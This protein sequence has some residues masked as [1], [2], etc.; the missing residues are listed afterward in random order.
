MLSLFSEKILSNLKK[1]SF[2]RLYAG[3]LAL[4][5]LLFMTYFLLYRKLEIASVLLLMIS[6]VIVLCCGGKAEKIIY[7][8]FL[9]ILVCVE[10]HFILHYNE[11][12]VKIGA[13][14]FITLHITS[15]EECRT[16]LSL[17]KWAEFILPLFFL[18]GIVA[19]CISQGRHRW[20]R[21]WGFAAFGCFFGAVFLN[22]FPPLREYSE[23]WSVQKEFLLARGRFRF[24][25]S[26]V[27]REARSLRI[28]IIGESH[29]QDYSDS[30]MITR[31]YAPLLWNAKKDGTA[32]F[33]SD[34]VSLYPQTWF[35]VF[36][37]LTRR[38]GND[39]ALYFSEK[40]LPSLFKEAGYKT[41]WV[42]YQPRGFAHSGYDSLVDECDAFYN[43]RDES[44]SKTDMGMLPIIKRLAGGKEDKIL[45]VIK[46]VGAHF[47]FHTRYPD[48]FK[49]YTPAYDEKTFSG[50][51]IEQKE[52]LINSYKNAMAYSGTVLDAIADV[53]KTSDASAMMAFISDHGMGLYDDNEQPFFGAIKGNYHIPFFIYGNDVY[54]KNLPDAKR[55]NLM[56]HRDIPVTTRYLFDTFV[57][58]SG[59]TYPQHRPAFDLTAPEMVPPKTRNV[60]V[61]NEQRDYETLHG[62]VGGDGR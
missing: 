39:R 12:F 45:I 24:D 53:V 16:Y 62:S 52:L 54:W 61:W 49:I 44:G 6:G 30:C 58:A 2:Y 29:R 59:V 46:M 20:S 10:R 22:V 1:A 14:A 35:A 11:P 32:I 34:M 25:A 23:Q 50:N 7:I 42:T 15:P 31:Q 17:L 48:E 19:V 18:G 27:S 28:L 3:E 40:G 37:E 26:D 47:N 13:Q 43:H 57:S 5:A 4:T 56:R 60:W 36:T 8:L 38:D 33:F 51:S 21:W 9:G 55:E 41:Y